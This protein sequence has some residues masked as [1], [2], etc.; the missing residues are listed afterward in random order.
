MP[1]MKAI[2][3]GHRVLW[4]FRDT[5][6]SLPE[7][8]IEQGVIWVKWSYG[9]ESALPFDVEPCFLN[10]VYAPQAF[11]F[12]ILSIIQGALQMCLK[13]SDTAV[14]KLIKNCFRDLI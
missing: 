7:D 2:C 10:K 9:W 3:A 6:L 13:I 4:R 8:H 5:T 11:S 12:V 1:W 14:N